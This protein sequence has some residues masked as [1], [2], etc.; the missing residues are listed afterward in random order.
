MTNPKSNA[1]P[2][3]TT[4]ILR[5]IEDRFKRINPEDLNSEGLEALRDVRTALEDLVDVVSAHKF[6]ESLGA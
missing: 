3:L 2:E 4:T 5:G 6:L 1:T